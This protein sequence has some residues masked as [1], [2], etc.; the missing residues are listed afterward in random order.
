MPREPQYEDTSGISRQRTSFATSSSKA[1]IG[2]FN[3]PL[4]S[5]AAAFSA[6]FITAIANAAVM[7]RAVPVPYFDTRY[8]VSA[9]VANLR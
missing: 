2:V 6:E 4:S 9:P 3:R 5:E 8:K 1:I 7:A